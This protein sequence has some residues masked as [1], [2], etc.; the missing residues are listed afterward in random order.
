MHSFR[1]VVEVLFAVAIV[2]LLAVSATPATQPS[3]GGGI[4]IATQRANDRRGLKLP[5]RTGS[6][7]RD[8]DAL[9]IEVDQESLSF[10]IRKGEIR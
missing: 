9:H 8:G 5:G 10:N 3:S 1:R 7:R 6:T 4:V 2:S